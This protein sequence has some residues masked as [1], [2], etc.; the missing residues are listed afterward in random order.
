M[1][2]FRRVF[3]SPRVV[4]ETAVT[5]V[6]VQLGQFE[7]VLISGA[8]AAWPEQLLLDESPD[9]RGRAVAEV[10]GS[11]DDRERPWRAHRARHRHTSNAPRS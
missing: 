6:A 2:E 7:E 11:L 1:P 8:S 4:R 10:L 5:D 9:P 3:H